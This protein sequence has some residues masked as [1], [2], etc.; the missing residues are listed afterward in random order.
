[1]ASHEEIHEELSKCKKTDLIDIIITKKVP[2]ELK[3]SAKVRIILENYEQ[4]D[5][6]HDSFKLSNLN[7]NS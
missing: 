4:K 1:M 2:S 3:L 7:R 6:L 5:I